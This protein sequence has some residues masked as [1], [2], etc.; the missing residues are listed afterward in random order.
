[1][2]EANQEVPQWLERY[3]ARSS[4]GFGGGRNRRSG[5]ARFGGRDFRRD[6][7]FRGGGG[8]GGGYGGA[9]AA[10]MVA[11]MVEVQQVPGTKYCF[12]VTSGN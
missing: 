4:Y 1:M 12:L 9:A 11:A 5:G 8:S 3:A 2:Q 10:D 7:D 6:R